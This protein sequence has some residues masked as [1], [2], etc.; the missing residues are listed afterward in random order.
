MKKCL[1][2]LFIG[3]AVIT[4]SAQTNTNNPILSGP[5]VD[6]FNFLSASASNWIIAPYGIASWDGKSFGG[7]LGVGYRITDMVVPTMRIDAVKSHDDFTVWMP[8][9]NLQLQLPIRIMNTV[10]VVPFT[11][12]GIAT[13][14]AGKH[15]QNGDVVGV[16]GV[17]GAIRLGTQWDLLADV[18]VWNGAGFNAEKQIRFGV[19]WKPKAW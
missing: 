17:G 1:V 4:A 6:A 19:G 5:G 9:A 14:V 18:E 7:G 12:G 13:P 8:Q 3:V 15:N 2:S 10:T 11:F 16:L